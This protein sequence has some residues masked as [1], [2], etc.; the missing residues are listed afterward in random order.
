MVDFRSNVEISTGEFF[1]G[2]DQRISLILQLPTVRCFAAFSFCFLWLG[3]IEIPDS[4]EVIQ[5]YAFI[6]FFS[7]MSVSFGSGLVY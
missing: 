7:L 1:N 2:E 3:A 6:R 4:L 5:D